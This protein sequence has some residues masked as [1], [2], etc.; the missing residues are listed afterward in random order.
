MLKR[1]SNAAR[2]PGPSMRVSGVEE[3]AAMMD[4]GPKTRFAISNAPLSVLATP[5]VMQIIARNDTIEEENKVRLELGMP[6]LRY[7]DPQHPQIDEALARGVLEHQLGLLM[8]ER[9][10]EDALA[11][12]K[13]LRARPSPRSVREQRQARRR[14]RW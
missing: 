6:M 8:T 2:Q 5:I 14:I 13:P 3:M 1:G 12:V 10:I 9:S 7:L 11:G 4:L